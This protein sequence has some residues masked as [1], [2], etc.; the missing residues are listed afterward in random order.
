MGWDH[1]NRVGRSDLYAR[2]GVVKCILMEI[3]QLVRDKKEAQWYGWA[4]CGQRY[5]SDYLGFNLS[6]VQRAVTNLKKDGV[7]SIKFFYKGGQ[8]YNH[9]QVNMELVDS[10]K[11]SPRYASLETASSE[12]TT[13]KDTNWYGF[14]GGC[15]CDMPD[16]FDATGSCR[17]CKVEADKLFD[18]LE[19]E[20]RD[21]KSFA[22]DP[23]DPATATEP[24]TD[25][26]PAHRILRRFAELERI[27]F[28]PLVNNEN[29]GMAAFLLETMDAEEIIEVM[30][31]VLTEGY[32][33][34]KI[35]TFPFFV[36][37][38]SS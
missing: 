2:N 6:T 9:Y 25:D 33:V 21:C 29:L 12:P 34:G 3:A 18:D 36:E 30:N 31:S 38:I 7:V 35:H 1:K 26:D 4:T 28:E 14:C 24:V 15:G 16:D 37:R 8:R 13:I 19:A 32:W 20:N 5:L 10:R 17:A 27:P 23:D 11:R 22:Y